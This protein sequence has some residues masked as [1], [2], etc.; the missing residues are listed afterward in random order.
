MLTFATGLFNIGF[1]VMLPIRKIAF[2]WSMV[3]MLCTIEEVAGNFLYICI[4]DCEPWQYLL[5]A[6]SIVLFLVCCCASIAK[7]CGERRDENENS[8]A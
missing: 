2:I 6:A 3:L 7:S 8:S 1:P 5:M 4:G